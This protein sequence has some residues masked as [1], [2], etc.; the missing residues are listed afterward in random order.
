M[1]IVIDTNVFM[2]AL[3]RDGF[4]REFIVKSGWDFIFP[5]FEFEEIFNYKSEIIRKS[6]LGETE[7]NS[8]FLLLLKYVRVVP[9]D[10]VVSFRDK[11]YG[12]IGDIDK[13]DV[14]FVATSLAF[15]CPI[16]SDDKHFLEQDVV[17]VLTTKKIYGDY[18]NEV[19]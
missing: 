6:G 18:E 3:I 1:N 15:G 4:T 8:V 2:S 7:F 16:W 13:D 17:E 5:E 12:I 9:M 11:A 14:I 19:G 10:V